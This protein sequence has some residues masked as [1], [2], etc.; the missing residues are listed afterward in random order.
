[1]SVGARRKI[2]GLASHGYRAAVRVTLLRTSLWL[3]LASSA[4]G[5]GTTDAHARFAGEVAYGYEQTWQAA[6]RLI[7]V[8]LQCTIT[9]RDEAMGFVLFEY[10]SGARTYPGS[11]EVVRTTSGDGRERVRVQVRLDAMP[12]YVERMVFERL[13][14]KLREDFG[15]ARDRPRGRVPP[16]ESARSETP[17]DTSSPSARSDDRSAGD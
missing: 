12:S 3:T 6:V 5:V 4:W 11:L 16:T 1:M 8:D 13:V 2:V 17:S 10:R 14:R 7:R 15:E 9:D